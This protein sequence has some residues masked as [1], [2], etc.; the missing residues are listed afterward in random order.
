MSDYKVSFEFLHMS[1]NGQ[2]YSARLDIICELVVLQLYNCENMYTFLPMGTKYHKAITTVC[3]PDTDSIMVA[4]ESHSSKNGVKIIELLD[5]WLLQFEES[6]QG[7]LSDLI[8]QHY[9][10]AK[11]VT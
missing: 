1:T 2:E 11:D 10:F 5:L 7:Y 8:K 4:I 3:R 9:Q 6:L